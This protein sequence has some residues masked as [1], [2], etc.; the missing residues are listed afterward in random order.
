MG[1]LESQF[2]AKLKKKIEARLP[3]AIVNK[4]DANYRQGFPDL[5]VLYKDQYA[6]LECKKIPSERYSFLAKLPCNWVVEYISYTSKDSLRFFFDG[7]TERFLEQRTGSVVFMVVF[8][9]EC[10]FDLM[11]EC[12]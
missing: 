8:P 3:G 12:S 4:N 7:S 9:D 6:I 1:V 5:I 10:G 2:Q 11:Y